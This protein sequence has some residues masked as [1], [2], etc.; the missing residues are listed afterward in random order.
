ML[1]LILASNKLMV[2]QAMIKISILNCTET[3]GKTS[4]GLE[5]GTVRTSRSVRKA[6]I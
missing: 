1:V 2:K 5:I 4:L 3:E 6:A